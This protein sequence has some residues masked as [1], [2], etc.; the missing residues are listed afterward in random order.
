MIRVTDS[1]KL[2]GSG[3][4]E[5]VIFAAQYSEYIDQDASTGSI[6]YIK[7]QAEIGGDTS[8]GWVKV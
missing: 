7:M 3:S 1:L 6:L 5:G 2:L 8:K 4:P